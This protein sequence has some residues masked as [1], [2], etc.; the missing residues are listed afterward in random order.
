[1]T[2]RK[3]LHSHT[4]EPVTYATVTLLSTH[5]LLNSRDGNPTWRLHTDKGDY[6]T[7]QDVSA[8]YTKVP[9]YVP[10]GGLLVELTL[11][12]NHRV[13]DVEITDGQA[14]QQ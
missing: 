7:E 2:P 1:M 4:R 12:K 13:W 10:T 11:G 6:D 5:R 9:K 14:S 3:S 8:A